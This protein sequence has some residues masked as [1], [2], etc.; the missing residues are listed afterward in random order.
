LVVACA[1]GGA[2]APVAG[3]GARAGQPHDC[4]QA[5][6]ERPSPASQQLHALFDAEW[7]NDLREDPLTASRL[8]D[9]R[10]DDRWPDDSPAGYER[11]AAHDRDVLARVRA[12]DPAPLSAMDRVSLAL[13]VRQREL[14]VEGQP[15]RLWHL[16][17]D[18]NGGVQDADDVSSAMPFTS[19]RDYDA[20]I[21]RLRAFP[22]YVEQTTE[23]LR[24]GTRE[25]IVHP[26]VVMERIPA[27]IDKQIVDDPEKSPFYA[28]LRRVPSGVP[29]AERDRLVR[30]AKAEITRAVVPAYRRFRDFFVREYLPACSPEVG[31]WQLPH[32]PEAYAYL[33]RRHTTTA[34]RPEEVHDVGLRE[35]A[36]IRAE[37]NALV[38]RIGYKGSLRDAFAWLRSDPQFFYADPRALFE[39]YGATA[40]RIDP[41]LVLLFRT[42]PRTPYGVEAIPDTIAPDATT[43]YYREPAADGS[44]GGTFFVNLYKPEARPKWEMMA[45]TMHESVPGHHLQIALANEQQGLPAFRRYG[46]WTA[47]VEGWALYAESLGDEMG[48]YDDPYSKLGQ[49]TYEMWRAVRLVVDTGMHAMRWDRKRAIDYFL[50]NTPKTELDVTNEI[51]RYIAWPGQALAYKIGQLEIRRLREQARVALGDRFDVRAFHDVVLRNGA[52][53]L[54][55]LRAQVG[56]WI[57]SAGAKPPGLGTG[58]DAGPAGSPAG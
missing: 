33:V 30:E 19:V 55:V 31:A 34:L 45:L 25:R 7:E 47:F 4:G 44:R 57:E 23:T 10:F 14:K 37:M 1:L 5:A 43:A 20:W 35:V 22:A 18:Q 2:C 9:H 28:P 26:R 16:V 6:S 29:A 46:E 38:E 8:G 24:E 12:I 39:A 54:D 27:Q 15:Y 53:P 41:K 32:G 56:E 58:A 21:A 3:S 40:K 11:R 51:D 50:E 36:R 52:V 17:L 42:L 48:L 13:F 49:L